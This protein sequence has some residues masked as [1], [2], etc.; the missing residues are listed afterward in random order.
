MGE[1]QDELWKAGLLAIG[2]LIQ[3]LTPRVKFTSMLIW[4]T[5]SLQAHTSLFASRSF[6]YLNAMWMLVYWALLLMY[7]LLRMKWKLSSPILLFSWIYFSRLKKLPLIAVSE[8]IIFALSKPSS[9]CWADT[10]SFPSLLK[11]T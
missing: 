3:W 9:Q 5:C 10:T 7:E 6:R 4:N 8:I 1:C 11:R 2:T